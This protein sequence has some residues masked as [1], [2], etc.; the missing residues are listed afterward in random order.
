MSFNQNFVSSP[1]D[2]SKIFG[3]EITA[4]PPTKPKYE[5][6]KRRFKEAGL[7]LYENEQDGYHLEKISTP[8]EAKVVLSTDSWDEKKKKCEI[9]FT[10]TDFS[11]KYKTRKEVAEFGENISSIISW[12]HKTVWYTEDGDVTI[13]KNGEK[14]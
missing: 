9:T 12:K 4:F 2:A 6:L 10:Y 3:F 7:E 8:I 1:I 11:L 13:W 5:T 14:K